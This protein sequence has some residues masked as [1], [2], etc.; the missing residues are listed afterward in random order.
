MSVVV[1]AITATVKLPRTVWIKRSR[2]DKELRRWS[3][4]V[5]CRKQQDKNKIVCAYVCMYVCMYAKSS[6][7]TFEWNAEIFSY[8]PTTPDRPSCRSL[9]FRFLKKFA[10]LALNCSRFCVVVFLAWVLLGGMCM[11]L[12]TYVL[13]KYT[14]YIWKWFFFCWQAI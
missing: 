6:M 1:F 12:C 14:N 3:E 5:E 10:V 2:L 13:H 7:A 9:R 4:G 11:Y 8:Q